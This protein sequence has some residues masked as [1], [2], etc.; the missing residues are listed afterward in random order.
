MTKIFILGAGFSKPAGLPLGTELFKIILEESKKS[1]LYGNILKNDIDSFLDYYNKNFETSITEKEI[2]FEELI[3]YLDIEHFLGLKGSDTFS[4]EGNRSQ[5][6]IK[7][8]IAKILWK[9]VEKMSDKDFK[10]YDSFIEKLE[11]HDIIIS[12]NYDT[13][14]EKCFER[15]Q[16]PYRL[17]LDRYK[18]V[19][20]MSGGID[21]DT[22]EVILLKMHGSIDWFDIT[23]YENS[24]QIFK[25]GPDFILPKHTIFS[26]RDIFLPKKIIKGPYPH[27]SPLNQI[28][29]V[30]NLETFFEINNTLTAPLLISPSFSKMVYLNPLREFWRGFNSAGSLNDKVGIIGFS[31]PEHDDYI[32][33]PL[34]NLVNNFQNYKTDPIIKKSKLKVIDFQIN[35]KEKLA[36][37]SRYPFINWKET[38][39][40]FEGFNQNAIDKLFDS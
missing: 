10:L 39:Y 34:F 38:T 6:V 7:N 2:N 31:L 22:Q 37:K 9:K 24:Y 16:K 12:F 32:K 19:E 30:E 14:L 20:F 25:E 33:Q 23:N 1:S 29:K 8:L 17:F 15:L 4:G 5:L 18:Y 27:E 26:N 13:I 3:S 40:H 21:T 11:P 36:F 28:Y 35:E